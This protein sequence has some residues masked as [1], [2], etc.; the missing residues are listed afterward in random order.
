MKPNRTSR[1]NRA[2]AAAAAGLAL[3]AS[4]GHA[5]DVALLN[6]SYDP[7]RELY[8]DYNAAFA[9]YWK[10][11]TGDTVTVKQSHGGSGKQARSVIDG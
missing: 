11:K 4:A 7:T 5:A 3:T 2:L 8:Q 9:K 6:V 10:D 1:L